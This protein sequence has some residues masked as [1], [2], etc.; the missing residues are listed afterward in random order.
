MQAEEAVKKQGFATTSIF[1]PGLLE[2]GDKARGMEKM[3]SA[4][5]SGVK[6]SDVAKAMLLDAKRALG[7]GEGGSSSAGAKPVAVFEDRAI[8]KAAAAGTPPVA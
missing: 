6:V 8:R 2:R 7:L 4:I 5:M 3:I 1:R